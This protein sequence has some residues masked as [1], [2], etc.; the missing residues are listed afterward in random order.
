M[1][2]TI[3]TK[4]FGVWCSGGSSLER[5][6]QSGFTSGLNGVLEGHSYYTQSQRIYL[7]NK[8][9]EGIFKTEIDHG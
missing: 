4:S 9:Y 8:S 6:G 7:A 3:A 1:K 5:N 2:S